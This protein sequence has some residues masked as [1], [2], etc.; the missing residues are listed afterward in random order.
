MPHVKTAL[1]IDAENLLSMANNQYSIRFS[2]IITANRKMMSNNINIDGNKVCRCETLLPILPNRNVN[3]VMPLNASTLLRRH[4]TPTYPIGWKL[5]AIDG[6]DV[7]EG[8]RTHLN[9]N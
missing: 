8:I 3:Y 6:F 4:L 1:P 9:T 7:I 2:G 5:H